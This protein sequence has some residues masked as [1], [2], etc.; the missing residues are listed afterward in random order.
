MKIKLRLGFGIAL[1]LCSQTAIVNAQSFTYYNQEVKNESITL[2]M[3][4]VSGGSF[5]MGSKT[6][7]ADE[8]P[9]HKVILDDFWMGKYE[10]T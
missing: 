4:A 7:E 2:D 9:I 6:R 3:I 8:K 10:I 1:L 5:N